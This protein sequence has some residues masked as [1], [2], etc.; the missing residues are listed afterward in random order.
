[1]L[2]ILAV[3]SAQLSSGLPPCELLDMLDPRPLFV[4]RMHMSGHARKPG[5]SI[6]NA[7][8]TYTPARTI[9]RFHI[10]SA[11]PSKQPRMVRTFLKVHTRPR[12]AYPLRCR[13]TQGGGIWLSS[14]FLFLQEQIKGIIIRLLNRVP[15]NNTSSPCAWRKKRRAIALQELK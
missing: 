6:S 2:Q 12:L 14:Y 11:R 4:E 15:K 1:M 5:F 8:S 9:L 13:S 10:I 3:K 7:R